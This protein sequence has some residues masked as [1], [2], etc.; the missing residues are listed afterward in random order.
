M[1]RYSVGLRMYLYDKS[2]LAIGKHSW[3]REELSALR[4]GLPFTGSSIK[5]LTIACV[6]LGIKDPLDLINHTPREYD[7]VD[8][9]GERTWA[10]AKYLI[11]HF[12]GWPAAEKWQH[13]GDRHPEAYRPPPKPPASIRT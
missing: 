1:P 8:G 7:S 11:A 10:V 5:H 4:Y 12:H 2:P 13:A 3:S 9:C 6:A